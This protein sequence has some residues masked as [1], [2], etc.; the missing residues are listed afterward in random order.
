METILKITQDCSSNLSYQYFID[1]INYLVNNID[2]FCEIKND[3]FYNIVEREKNYHSS[4]EQYE[5]KTVV[6]S[7][8]YSQRDWQTYVLYH[9]LKQNNKDL[10]CLCN[11]L[12]KSF[13]HFNDYNAGIIKR[14][15]IGGILYESEN[16]DSFSFCIR[17]IEFPDKKDILQAYNNEYGI[18]YDKYEIYI[19]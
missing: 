3:K 13:T 9:N 8:G 6:E 17:Y 15:E 16:I 7:I 11:E 12:K 19:D 10:I 4:K 2:I 14:T 18:N 1:E 5:N